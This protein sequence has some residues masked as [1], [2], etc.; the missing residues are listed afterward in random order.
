MNK[1]EIGRKLFKYVNRMMVFMWRLGM[2]KLLCS[3]PEVIGTYMVITHQGRKSGKQ[4]QTPVN[5]TE[6]EGDLYCT[7]GFGP[8]SDWYRNIL[9]NPQVEVWITDGWFVGTAESVDIDESNLPILRSILINSG[10]VTWII[11]MN[12]KT[13]SDEGLLDYLKDYR[14]VRIR[15]QNARTGANGPGDLAWVWPLIVM[16]MML[17]RC[18]RRKK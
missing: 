17:S 13:I 6:H 16:G 1:N 8:G 12:P 3:W 2:G 11:G 5:F 15:R 10:F 14:L 18:S 9:V 4:F 7:T